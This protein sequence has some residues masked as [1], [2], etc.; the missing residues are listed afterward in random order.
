MINLLIIG[1]GIGIGLFI[2]IAFIVGVCEYFVDARD[3]SAYIEKQNEWMRK[4]LERA[5]EN[6][7]K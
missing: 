2:L 5:N 1:T 7:P 4:G 6:K 3:E